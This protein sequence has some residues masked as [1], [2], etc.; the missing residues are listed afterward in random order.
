MDPSNYTKYRLCLLA[1]IA[2]GERILTEVSYDVKDGSIKVD[3]LK[4]PD[5]DESRLFK[6]VMMKNIN[7]LDLSGT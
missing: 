6:K 4:I 1:Q 7:I 2:G 5:N 3:P